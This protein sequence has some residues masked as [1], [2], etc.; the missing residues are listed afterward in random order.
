MKK[1]LFTLLMLLSATF[2]MAQYRISTD[3]GTFS[4]QDLGNANDYGTP[5]PKEKIFGH[6]ISATRVLVKIEGVTYNP[7]VLVKNQGIEYTEFRDGNNSDA[8]FASAA[9]VDAW[10]KQNTG[11]KTASGGSGASSFSELSGTIANNQVPE[12]AVAQ[13]QL[14]YRTKLHRFITKANQDINT[15]N[16]NIRTIG[17]SI[18]AGSSSFATNIGNSLARLYGQSSNIY[19]SPTT[20][21]GVWELQH[22][23]GPFSV[24]IKGDDTDGNWGRSDIQGEEFT[25]FYDTEPDG[26]TVNVTIDGVAQT[27]ISC[28]GA[29]S[30]GNTITYTIDPTKTIQVLFSAQNDGFAYLSGYY[31]DRG[32]NGIVNTQQSYGGSGLQHH[33][34]TAVRDGNAGVP[35]GDLGLIETFATST[36][37]VKPDLVIYQGFTNDGNESTNATFA[38]N[39]EKAVDYTI[40]NGSDMILIIE[41]RNSFGVS[42]WDDKAAA[43]YAMETKYPNNILLLDWDKYM[44]P[45]GVFNTDFHSENLNDPHPGDYGNGDPHAIA[46]NYFLGKMNLPYGNNL[47]K[48]K[49]ALTKPLAPLYNP[50]FI[51]AVRINNTDQLPAGI[52][53]DVQGNVRIGKRYVQSGNLN[54]DGQ[55]L[56]RNDASGIARHTIQADDNSRYASLTL[57]NEEDDLGVD[58]FYGGSTASEW[59]RNRLAAR[60]GTNVRLMISDDG[61]NG[62]LGSATANWHVRASTSNIASLRIPHGVAPTNPNDG[63]IWTTTAGI[64]IRING[65]TY[66]L[67]ATSE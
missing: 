5:Y 51:G 58:I 36:E 63:D 53:F 43:M 47:T 20:N 14:S 46:T 2:A 10:F 44:F 42:F 50:E 12:S 16:V 49:N 59:M 57:R 65:V 25:I 21:Y 27:P 40:A 37:L 34:G 41:P 62:L 19:G 30:Y 54:I 60:F 3:N 22:Y 32:D 13:H 8:T 4:I 38:A 66:K 35:S 39:L 15:G 24:R 64:F 23:S 31:I 67:D 11:F 7:K 48:V 61:T 18:A 1:Q 28:N 17:T 29:T 52:V 6:Q 9:A 55:I 45:D 33:A 56:Q 26:G